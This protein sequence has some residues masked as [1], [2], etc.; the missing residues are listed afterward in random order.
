VRTLQRTPWARIAI[1]A[2]GVA[3]LIVA[4]FGLVGGPATTAHRH[5]SLSYRP[6]HPLPP[7]HRRGPAPLAAG[8]RRAVPRPTR[9]LGRG[10]FLA[11]QGGVARLGPGARRRGVVALTFDDGPGPMTAAFLDKLGQL[12][13]KA[14]FFV[15]GYNVN[16][17]PHVLRRES[18]MGMGIGNH[19]WAHP[20]MRALGAAGQRFQILSDEDAIQNVVGYRPLFFRPPYLSFNLTTARQIALAGMVGAL[21]TVDTRDW[22]RPG[23]G[24]IVRR[25]L[26]VEPGG[27]IGMHD[28]GADRSQTLAALGPIVRRLRKRGLEPV[29]LDELYGRSPPAGG[30]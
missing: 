24:T 5:E 17:R 4:I 23:K 9:F 14:T 15:V 26:T 13:V 8:P 10:P 28:A 22:T 6:G 16:R 20:P 30:P 11:V 2:P 12:H 18:E 25:A 19:S 27:V 29:T 7:V 1:A 21:W 3:A